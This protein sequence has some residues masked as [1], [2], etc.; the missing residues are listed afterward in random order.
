M[1]FRPILHQNQPQRLPKTTPEASPRRELLC[2][3]FWSKAAHRTPKIRRKTE[4]REE[5]EAFFLKAF[6]LKNLL[7]KLSGFGDRGQSWGVG[8]QFDR[9]ISNFHKKSKFQILGFETP[10]LPGN[11]PNRCVSMNDR[12]CS[13]LRSVARRGAQIWHFLCFLE[14]AYK[15]VRAGASKKRSSIEFV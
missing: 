3:L 1:C 6:F 13:V 5:G 2:V 7:R 8:V 10:N 14:I 15:P 4:I 11:K 9:F 12:V